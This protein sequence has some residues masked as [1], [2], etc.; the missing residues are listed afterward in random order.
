M[1]FE[2]FQIFIRTQAREG[3]AIKEDTWAQNNA[4]YQVTSEDTLVFWS[5]RLFYPTGKVVINLH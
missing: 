5:K 4:R 2:M 3:R 1:F